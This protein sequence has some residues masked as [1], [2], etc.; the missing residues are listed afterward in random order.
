MDNSVFCSGCS[1]IVLVT[2]HVFLFIIKDLHACSDVP[3][4]LGGWAGKCV[5]CRSVVPFGKCEKSL[6]K[7]YPLFSPEQNNLLY[8]LYLIKKR[9]K[10]RGFM[11]LFSLP[12]L[13]WQHQIPQN[14]PRQNAGFQPI[15][16]PT[17]PNPL[18]QKTQ[19]SSLTYMSN[20]AIIIV[21]RSNVST[22]HHLLGITSFI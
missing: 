4:I 15:F 12:L 14:K 17:A 5:F 13:F 7:P 6:T 19:I 10:K 2:E 20:N 9:K 21:S 11:R 3:V 16:V 22:K 1:V 18:E 8:I